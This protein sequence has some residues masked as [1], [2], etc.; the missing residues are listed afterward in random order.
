MKQFGRLPIFVNHPDRFEMVRQRQRDH[1]RG[2]GDAHMVTWLD[3]TG[4][5]L[6][7]VTESRNP[8]PEAAKYENTVLEHLK[9]IGT[10]AI[11]KLLFDSLNRNHQYWIVPLDLADR[12]MCHC[13]AYVF[14]GAPKEGGGTRIYYNPA[15]WNPPS[16]KWRAADDVL[17]HELVHAYREGRLGY[18]AVNKGKKSMNGYDDQEE[19]LALHMQNVYLACRGASRYYRTYRRLEPVSKHTAYQ[20]FA[21]EAEALM[22]LR[23]FVENEPLA[24]EVAR[25]KAP[26]DSF[27]PWRD[28]EV[29]ERLFI[30]NASLGIDRLPPF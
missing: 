22:A 1:F 11:G 5:R 15:D 21:G 7:E 23:H 25:W 2:L 30:G 17:F 27:N 3:N 20:Y 8:G 18:E 26:A 28:Q 6:Y 24:A 14:P 12:E 4:K 29:L 9:L 13:G 16:R 10:T 19:F